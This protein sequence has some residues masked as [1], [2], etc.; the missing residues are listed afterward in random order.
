MNGLLLGALLV[1]GFGPL[2]WSFPW[3]VWALAILD[4]LIADRIDRRRA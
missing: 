2:A 3:W 4:A 1:L